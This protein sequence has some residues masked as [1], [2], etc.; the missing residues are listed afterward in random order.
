MQETKIIIIGAG[1][2]GIATAC[3]LKMN[4]INDFIILEKNTEVGGTWA[5]NTYPGVECDVESHL[6]SYSFFPK[7]DWSNVYASGSE[8]K[9]YLKNCCNHFKIHEHII[10]STNV[11]SCFITNG[12]WKII[13][14]NDNF[15]CDYLVCSTAPLHKENIPEIFT[16]FNGE[17]LHT[18]KWNSNY[19]FTNK[20]VAIVGN[21]AS[22]IQC[23]PY[24]AK[25]CQ[26][27]TIFQRTPNWVLPK[28]NRKY[29]IFEQWLFKFNLFRRMYRGIIYWQREMTFLIFKK[30]SIL[31]RLI[32]QLSKYYL[33]LTVSSKN[34]REKLVPQYPIGCKRILLSDNYYTTLNLSNINLVTDSITKVTTD[35]IICGENTYN[36]D[37]IVLATGFDIQGATGSYMIL[38]KNNKI[39]NTKEMYYGIHVKDTPNLFFLL[40]ANSGSGHTSSIYY[41][42]CQVEYIVKCIK[43]E[44]KY[45]VNECIINEF[46][47]TLQK[48]FKGLVWNQCKSWYQEGGKIIGLYPGFSFEYKR[49]LGKL[50]E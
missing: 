48:Q 31:G 11:Q 32:E 41:I 8:I 46:N 7:S 17:L 49:N 12:K 5:Y 24:L 38:D 42:E 36:I 35:S 6:Y 23:I 39:I 21:A 9:E 2:S 45:E 1:I 18:A 50:I 28:G 40:G 33:F 27:V 44:K 14:Q 19:S 25:E 22:G 16:T 13:T 4:N 43:T 3:Q 30:M 34:L 26:S 47:E 15:L 29:A 20:N 37:C 10:F